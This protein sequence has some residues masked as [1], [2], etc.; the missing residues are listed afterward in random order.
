[1]AVGYSHHRTAP[2]ATPAASVCCYDSLCCLLRHASTKLDLSHQYR[3]LVCTDLY[4]LPVESGSQR[5]GMGRA[6]KRQVHMQR[7]G[8][9][10]AGQRQQSMLL[11]PALHSIR[12]SQQI[13][14][15]QAGR[16]QGGCAST[17]S[18]LGKCCFASSRTTA[19][20]GA[21]AGSSSAHAVFMSVSVPMEVVRYGPAAAT[22][23]KR[24][25]Q[26]GQVFS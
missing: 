18:R 17:S 25:C 2:P 5:Q 22:V 9:V 19:L 10:H 8:D 21:V 24:Y 4:L 12:H 3:T 13:H 23:R 26:R 11:G 20:G 16:L 15:C 6:A 14:L 1:M 7:A